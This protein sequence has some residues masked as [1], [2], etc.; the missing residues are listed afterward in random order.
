VRRIEIAR[1][2][3]RV[4]DQKNRTL[5]V[6]KS[7]APK[8]RTLQSA[9]IRAPIRKAWTIGIHSNPASAT[10]LYSITIYAIMSGKFAVELNV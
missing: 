3:N 10:R 4:D 6:R 9:I 7:A 5:E 8:D 2:K 1:W